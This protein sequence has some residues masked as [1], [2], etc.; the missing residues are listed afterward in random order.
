M[1][2]DNSR[3]VIICFDEMK[4]LIMNKVAKFREVYNS[5]KDETTRN[6]HLD[7]KP[8]SIKDVAERYNVSK[9][10]VHNWMKQGIIHGF[11]QGK[12]RYFYLHELDQKLTH[13]KYIERIDVKGELEERKRP[14]DTF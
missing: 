12:G 6:S 5:H 4:T 11:K 9:Q 14:V 8:L 10:T 3:M 7:I 2:S 13:Y 1:A